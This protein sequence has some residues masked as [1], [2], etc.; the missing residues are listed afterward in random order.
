[1]KCPYCENE[2]VQ[3]YI[4]DKQD[5]GFLWLPEGETPPML[6][7]EKS[8]SKKDGIYRKENPF[9]DARKLK[10]YV[11]QNCNVGITKFDEK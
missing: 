3:G 10:M 2:M 11:C 8:V 4:W 9:L 5:R 1:M 7:T 6:L